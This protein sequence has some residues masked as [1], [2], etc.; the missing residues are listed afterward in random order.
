MTAHIDRR[1]A[2]ALLGGMTILPA[3]TT[4]PAAPALAPDRELMVPVEGGRIHVRV[5]GPLDGPRAPLLMAHGGPGGSH[6][7]FLPALPLADERAV[8][9]YDQLDSGLSDRPGDPANWT[10]PRFVSEVDSIREALSLD[11]LHLLGHS[12]GATVAL[13]Y[14]AARPAGLSSLVLQGPLISTPV[15][16]EDAARLR[17][18]LPAPVQAVLDRCEG[19]SAPP[20]AECEAATNAFYDRFWRLRPPPPAFAAYETAHNQALSRKVYETMWGPNEFRATGTL[21]DYDGE[22]L[23][24][25]IAAPTLFLIGDSDEI[26]PETA[27]RFAGQVAGGEVETIQNAAHRIQTDRTDAYNDALRRW[28]RRFD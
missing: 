27:L 2:L 28:M 6:S 9:L 7:V 19:A 17:A 11:R 12:W 26:L 3:C 15:W 21:K 5:N 24:A 8:I 18:M 25:K 16:S 14:A 10:V 13:E 1:S 22:P 20:A 23:L 4:L